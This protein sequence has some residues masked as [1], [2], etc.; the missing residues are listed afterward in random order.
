M[1]R[2]QAD[3]RGGHEINERIGR[4][5]HGGVDGIQ[6]RLV[7]LGAGHGQ[8]A[9]VGAG[10]KVGFGPQAAGHDD[11]AVFGQRLADGLQAFGLGA[12][13]KPAGVHDHGLGAAVVGADRIAFGAQ[14]GQ[15]PLAVDQSLGAAHADHADGRLAGAGGLDPGFGGEIGAQG[16][17][18]LGHGGGIANGAAGLNGGFQG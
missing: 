10:D 2:R 6:N 8:H 14:P 5:R 18:V 7:L 15:Y 12:V 1:A 13:E 11:P 9:G 16:G 17:R 4:G 3:A